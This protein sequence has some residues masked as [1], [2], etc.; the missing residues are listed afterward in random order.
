M[1]FNYLIDSVFFT[2]L[3]IIGSDE[4]SKYSSDDG[5]GAKPRFVTVPGLQKSTQKRKFSSSFST[6]TIDAYR[7]IRVGYRKLLF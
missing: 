6:I 1:N 3:G 5:T 7:S 4:K 2:R